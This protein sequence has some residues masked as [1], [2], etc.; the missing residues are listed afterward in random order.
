[1]WISHD[2]CGLGVALAPFLNCDFFLD[3]TKRVRAESTFLLLCLLHLCSPRELA[4]SLDTTHVHA[5]DDLGPVITPHSPRPLPTT[6][7][8]TPVVVAISALATLTAR[9]RCLTGLWPIVAF[10][11]IIIIIIKRRSGK[12]PVHAYHQGPLLGMST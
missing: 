12:K 11:I 10:I 6:F 9:P 3:L 7:A 8:A 4:G 2:L 1:M 5:H